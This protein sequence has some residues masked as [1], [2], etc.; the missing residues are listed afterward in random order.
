MWESIALFGVIIVVETHA[1]RHYVK[2]GAGRPARTITRQL[3]A[4]L[5]YEN[6]GVAS[7]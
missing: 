6:G 3:I 5:S 2:S 7:R 1:Y 4:T